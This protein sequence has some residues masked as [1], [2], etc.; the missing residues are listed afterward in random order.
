MAEVMWHMP[1]LLSG[2]GPLTPRGPEDGPPALV[3]PGFVANDRTTME[4]RRA[5]A[6][7]GW[8]VHGWQAGSTS[9]VTDPILL[10]ILQS[11]PY[12]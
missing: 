8:R 11:G 2:L 1:R 10:G 9:A 12:V 7:S 4:L 6:T 3:I 5:L